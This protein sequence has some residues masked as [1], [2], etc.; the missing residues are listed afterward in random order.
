MTTLRV[1]LIVWVRVPSGP[2]PRQTLIPRI[3]FRHLWGSR[4]KLCFLVTGLRRLLVFR[5]LRLFL[6]TFKFRGFLSIRHGLRPTQLRLF[7]RRTPVFRLFSAIPVVLFGPTLMGRYTLK[8]QI[9]ATKV[10]LRPRSHCGL[11][12]R[13]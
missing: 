12:Y 11:Y 5:S 3:R 10:R 6:F 4:S 1:R 9:N 7:F 2:V 13:H 8:F